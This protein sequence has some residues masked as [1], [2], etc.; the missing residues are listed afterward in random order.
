MK[1][2]LPTDAIESLESTRAEITAALADYESAVAHVNQRQGKLVGVES[3]LSRLKQ[4]FDP[5]D[6]AAVTKISMLEKQRDL[7]ADGFGPDAQLLK[8][9]RNALCRKARSGASTMAV[10]LG[11]YAKTLFAEI[12]DGLTP[13]FNSR[14]RAMLAVRNTDVMMRYGAG[15]QFLSGS[16][17]E[18]VDSARTLLSQIENAVQ[19]NNPFW[20]V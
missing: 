5:M 18:G 19:G 8:E 17:I 6:M 16:N 10:V 13:F 14:E 3:E 2:N 1:M 12:A 7:M 15:L 20:S 11:D 9:A 4:E